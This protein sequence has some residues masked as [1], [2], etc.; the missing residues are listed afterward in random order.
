MFELLSKYHKLILSLLAM[1]LCVGSLYHHGKVRTEPSAFEQTMD[2]VTS[3]VQLLSDGLIGGVRNVWT[4]YVFL[5]GLNE[6]NRVLQA[7]NERLAGESR[8]GKRIRFQNERLKKLV[9]F[10]E[11]NSNLEL[12][13]ARVIGRDISPHYRVLNLELDSGQDRKIREGMPVVTHEGVVGRVASVSGTTSKVMLVVD[14]R[15]TM[16]VRIAG[17]GVTGTLTGAG[18]SNE[19][20]AKFRFLY[21][22]KPVVSRD[23]V[24]TSGHDQVFPSGLEVGRILEGGSGQQGLYYVY[25]VVPAV[26]FSTLEE[27]FVVTASE[28]AG[29]E[30]EGE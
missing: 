12:V 22:S 15:S 29:D 16:N 8:R 11:K 26:N 27:V 30:E 24:V 13:A 20:E 25:R 5:V 21:R 18:A 2:R 28:A 1:G 17:K 10:K 7:E 14:S 9:G 4:S 19:Y 3:P 6:E 23:V